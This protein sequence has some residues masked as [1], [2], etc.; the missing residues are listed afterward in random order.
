MPATENVMASTMEMP[1]E[2]SSAL[3]GLRKRGRLKERHSLKYFCFCEDCN[4]IPIICED[5]K[6]PFSSIKSC[7]SNPMSRGSTRSNLSRAL[8]LLE[9]RGN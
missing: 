3:R 8:V 4:M 9:K 2:N 1:M 5:S 6:T 7:L